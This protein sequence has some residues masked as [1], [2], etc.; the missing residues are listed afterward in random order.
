[1]Q[2]PRGTKRS[3]APALLVLLAAAT[4]A[5]AVD[6]V[7]EINQARAKAGGVTGSDTA[8]FP[9]ILDHPGSYRLT[10][11]LDVTD[12]TARPNGTLAENT[13][14]IVVTANYVSIDLNGF[15]ILGP[16][17]CGGP[18]FTVCT[19]AGS[20]KGIDASGREGVSI[21]NGTVKGMGSDGASL[22]ESARVDSVRAL[23]N[24]GT[25][26]R[27]ETGVVTN[28]EASHNG[29][30]G[31]Y[32]AQTIANSFAAANRQ[33]GLLSGTI[34]NSGAQSNGGVGL[35]TVTALGCQ[36]LGNNGGNIVAD[37]IAGQNICAGNPC[38]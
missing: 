5:F 16:E 2:P 36:S 7:V 30:N 24:A 27:M 13:T 10:S 6:G 15:S 22:G 9:V 26:L 35:Q 12:A 31:V 25:G 34:I 4:P 29:D 23:R 37:G 32:G 14:A 21:V 3:L 1:M 8:R 11:N 28:S 33:I 18:P 19:P 17:V 38:P 20:G